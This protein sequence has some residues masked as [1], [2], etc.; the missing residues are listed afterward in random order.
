MVLNVL[1][2][3]MVLVG[4]LVECL[5]MRNLYSFSVLLSNYSFYLILLGLFIKLRIYPFYYQVYYLFLSLNL[6]QC[7]VILFL[8][9]LIPIILLIEIRVSNSVIRAMVLLSVVIVLVSSFNGVMYNDLRLVVA[10]SSISYLRFYL[11]LIPGRPIFFL[12]YFFFYYSVIVLFIRSF[13]KNQEVYLNNLFEIQANRLRKG[14]FIL[15]IFVLSRIPPFFIF[16]WKLIIL[17]EVLKINL[18]MVF[19]FLLCYL[20]NL[21]FYMRLLLLILR[22]SYN[23]NG[24]SSLDASTSNSYLGGITRV[25]MFSTSVMFLIFL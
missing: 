4:V 22:V 21:I 20:R 14:F 19:V 1:A 2:R 16:M 3:I 6:M 18:F 10:F 24:L 11:L 17:Y 23:Y 7:I 12:L 9:K 5:F 13:G 8:P 15:M 25:L